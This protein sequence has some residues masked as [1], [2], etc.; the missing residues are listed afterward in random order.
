MNGAGSVD[1]L[2]LAVELVNTAHTPAGPADRLTDVA[3]FQ[4]VLAE[5]GEHR[6]A[7]AMAPGDLRPLRTL[8]DHLHGVFV[9]E[10]AAAAVPLLNELLTRAGAVPQLRAVGTGE[11]RLEWGA[12]RR[13]YPALAARLPGALAEF[14]TE[15][16]VRR[17]GACAA[18]PC[19]R[20]FVDRTRP[21][22][23]RYC[24]EQ[25]NDR[26]ASAAYR[27]RRRTG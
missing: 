24:C 13:G 19:G 27:E 15:H 12:G 8:R 14:V 21:G 22:N 23:R 10:T 7:K 9:A 4:D 5:F 2:D 18:T 11:A 25:C 1:D 17:L 6:L 20:V 3:H 26:V 16:G